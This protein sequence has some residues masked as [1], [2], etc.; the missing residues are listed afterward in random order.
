MPCDTWTQPNQTLEQRK[1]QV[2]SVIKRVEDLIAQRKVTVKVGATGGIAFVGLTDA[3]R[4]KVTDAC[5]YRRIMATGS[6]LTKNAIQQA[7]K[8]AGRAVDKRAIATG[9]HSHDGGNTWHHGH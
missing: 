9:V 8:L 4:A 2:K 5:I 3:D 1:E 7:E 6:A